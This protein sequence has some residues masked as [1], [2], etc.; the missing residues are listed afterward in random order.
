MN[1]KSVPSEDNLDLAL[2]GY[3]QRAARR[4]QGK[5]TSEI[6]GFAATA[7]GLAFAGG[8]AMANIVH[9]NTQLSVSWNAA[10]GGTFNA[11]GWDIDGNGQADAALLAG[12]YSPTLLAGGVAHQSLFGLGTGVALFQ[13]S[14]TTTN[15]GLL[16]MR[17]T[18]SNNVAYP[19]GA[20]SLFN[21]AALLGLK[22]IGGAGFGNFLST[23]GYLGFAFG[24]ASLPGP[25]HGWA[26]VRTDINTV[27]IPSAKV[28]VFE[29]AYDDSGAPIH[30]ADRAS[31]SVPVPGTSMLALLGLGAL[32][33]QGFRRRREDGLKRLAAQQAAED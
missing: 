17:L 30:V 12:P 24:N 27:G 1:T 28:T 13:N 11:A 10:T 14:A 18:Q 8:D 16:G 3:S 26:K 25:I 23:T 21:I 32:G 20:S 29:W 6:L 33:V 2:D 15:S 19:G 9:F 7:G 22:S 4:K 5:R 31:A